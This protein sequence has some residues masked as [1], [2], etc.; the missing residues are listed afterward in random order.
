MQL[1]VFDKLFLG[2]DP[3]KPTLGKCLLF[4]VFDGEPPYRGRSDIFYIQV[5]YCLTSDDSYQ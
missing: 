1:Q 3:P 5:E 2:S 4:C